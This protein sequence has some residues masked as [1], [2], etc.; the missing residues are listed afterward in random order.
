M[1]CSGNS[2]SEFQFN[3]ADLVTVT[4][5]HGD[6]LLLGQELHLSVQRVCNIKHWINL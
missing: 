4:T 3:V 6:T 5:S 1:N 2:D